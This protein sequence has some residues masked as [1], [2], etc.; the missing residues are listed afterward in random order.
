MPPTSVRCKISEGKLQQFDFLPQEKTSKQKK[1]R[2]CK[3]VLTS[4][5][6][7]CTIWSVI[8][9]TDEMLNAAFST[10]TLTNWKRL[11]E[12][13]IFCIY[14][15]IKADLVKYELNGIWNPTQPKHIYCFVEYCRNIMAGWISFF[16]SQVSDGGHFHVLLNPIQN[17][18]FSRDLNW[19]LYFA[20]PSSSRWLTVG[21]C[22]D[23][24]LPSL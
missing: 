15:Q 3:E 21:I 5:K 16:P 10:W 17:Q 14:A 13:R 1:G 22:W 6:I 19:F 23:R 24:L 9:V 12:K 2:F 11:K 8:T 18:N 20:F 4:K 7:K